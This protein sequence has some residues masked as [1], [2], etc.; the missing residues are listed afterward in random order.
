MPVLTF[1]RTGRDGRPRPP[2]DIANE[3]S[4]RA[5]AKPKSRNP[6]R[7]KRKQSYTTT[8]KLARAGSAPSGSEYR[9]SE[10]YTLN[11]RPK[12]N[13]MRRFEYP[14]ATVRYAAVRGRTALPSAKPTNKVKKSCIGYRRGE[15]LALLPRTKKDTPKVS[16]LV[17][18]PPRT[19]ACGRAVCFGFGT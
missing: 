6:L 5:E 3:M 2:A 8:P 11:L 15:V 19:T 4:F 17:A 16:F 1:G 13:I 18:A 10:R 7:K 14:P 9:A 12:L